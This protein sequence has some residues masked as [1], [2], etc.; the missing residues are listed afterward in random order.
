MHRFTLLM[1]LG[2]LA[3]PAGAQPFELEQAT[4][5]GGGGEVSAG[6][7]TLRGVINPQ[8]GGRLEAGVFTLTGG[9]FPLDRTDDT[10]LADTNGDGI[11]SPADFNGWII[12]FNNQSAACDQNNDGFCTPA[13]FNAWIVNFNAGCD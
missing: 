1:T 13:D 12:A 11:L 8:A 9:L 2:V 4:I 10:C 5:A 6:T 7:F 3:A